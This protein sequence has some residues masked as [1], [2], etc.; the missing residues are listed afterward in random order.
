[1]VSFLH[2]FSTAVEKRGVEVT[3]N[4]QDE[5]FQAV[6]I[7]GGS[8]ELARLGQL[9]RKGVRLVQRLDGINWIHRRRNMPLRH[10]LRAEY[11]N[12]LLSLLRRFWADRIVY[13]SEFSRRWWND[14]FGGLSTPSW[15]IH[16]GV[17]LDAYA[18]TSSPLPQDFFRLLLV[19]GSLGGG[20]EMGLQNAVH[21]AEVAAPL[22]PLPLRLRVVGEANAALKREWDA[23]SR[24]GLE[25]QG[26]L[27]REEIP[28]QMNLAHAFFSADLH[29]ACPNAVIEA[30]ACGLP[31]VAYDTGSLAELVP[32]SAGQ[33][34][35][36][37]ADSWRLQPPLAAPLAQGLAQ[38]LQRQSDFR[39]GA[40]AHAQSAL[41]LETMTDRYLDVLL[42]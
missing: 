23:R 9:R 38:V 3:A 32:A 36:Y 14:W 4:L 13:Q 15:V 25:W 1:M 42:G 17:D 26:K 39:A 27:R 30:L 31:V 12:L 8:R 10:S 5:S 18:P 7:I 28:A 16:N 41:G 24:V 20:Y 35:P 21:L 40:R 6:L 29:P 37:G 19:E 11:G 34:A 22:L 33:I 2:K